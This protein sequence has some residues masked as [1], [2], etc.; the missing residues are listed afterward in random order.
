M[1]I[2]LKSKIGRMTVQNDSHAC[3]AAVSTLFPF[4]AV[5]PA[6]EYVSCGMTVKNVRNDLCKFNKLHLQQLKTCQWKLLF[7]DDMT[8]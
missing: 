8:S 4:F 6:Y 2:D 3:A 7:A 5:F 1:R